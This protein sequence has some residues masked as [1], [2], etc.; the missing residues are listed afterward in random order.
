[1][2]EDAIQIIASSWKQDAYHMPIDGNALLILEQ[3]LSQNPIDS[4]EN[5]TDL[6]NVLFLCYL[7]AIYGIWGYTWPKNIHCYLNTP[8]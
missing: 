3:S 5:R 6:Q 1:M 4:T 7:T 2:V 8:T